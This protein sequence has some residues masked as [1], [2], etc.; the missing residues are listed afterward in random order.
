MKNKSGDY[1]D[2]NIVNIKLKLKTRKINQLF[3]E[4]NLTINNK[5]KIHLQSEGIK[6]KRHRQLMRVKVSQKVT[7]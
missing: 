6:R 5:S 4:E 3:K 1:L 7:K 2:L